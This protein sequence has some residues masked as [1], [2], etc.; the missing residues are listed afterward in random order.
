MEN[1][2]NELN[3][4]EPPSGHDKEDQ[5]SSK[6]ESSEAGNDKQEEDKRPK[7]EDFLKLGQNVE[8]L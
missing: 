4:G 2:V 3:K 8:A 6:R 7:M 1:E 5:P